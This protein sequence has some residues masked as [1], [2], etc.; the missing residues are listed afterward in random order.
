MNQI[1]LISRDPE[2]QQSMNSEC[3]NLRECI[4]SSFETVDEFVPQITIIT[5]HELIIVDGN[6]IP[7]VSG[8]INVLNERKEKFSRYILFSDRQTTD[9]AN[10]IVVRDRVE[11]AYH[12]KEVEFL[13]QNSDRFM[14]IS[15][16]TLSHFVS[17]PFP[18]Y[19]S[20]SSEKFVKRIPAFEPFDFRV[21]LSYRSRGVNQFFFERI[22]ARDFSALLMNSMLGRMETSFEDRIEKDLLL[23]E[24]FGN[25][26]EIISIIGLQPKVI[27]LCRKLMDKITENVSTAGAD[28]LKAYL[29]RLRTSTELNFHY[30]LT[31]LTTFLS[32]EILGETEG[33][34]DM[35][36]AAFFCDMSLRNP[37]DIHRRTNS[38]VEHLPEEERDSILGHAAASAELVA[39]RNACS[40]TAFRIILQHHG[41]VDGIGFPEVP[42]EG[43]EGLSGHFIVAHE[44]AYALL[45]RTEAGVWA[46]CQDL[47][48]RFRSTTLEE[49][50]VKFEVKILKDKRWG[51]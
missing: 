4:F 48:A 51:L 36:F 39:F 29:Q 8:I 21:L 2:F 19:I 22:Y 17:L 46:V 3:Q 33:M 7:D 12:L 30:R 34:E 35:T 10:F 42:E 14:G 25:V 13:H 31:E 50:V 41:A 49:V 47:I 1:I 45:T 9:D 38:S 15:L 6:S 18:L 43:I 44:L 37:G 23:A 20:L 5:G 24:T 27:E 40:T 28:D 16:E 26:R 11:L 32:G